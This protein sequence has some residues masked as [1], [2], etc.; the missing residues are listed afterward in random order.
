MAHTTEKPAPQRRRPELVATRMTT[1]E[2]AW[3]QAVAS[4]EGVSVTDLIYGLVM[5]SVRERLAASLRESE[6]S[7]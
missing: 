6:V 2:K 3:V 7:A 1:A 5:P 4:A